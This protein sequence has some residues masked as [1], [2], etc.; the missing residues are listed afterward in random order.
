MLSGLIGEDSIAYSI[1]SCT[2]FLY[3]FSEIQ[4]HENVPEEMNA[5]SK[6]HF[7]KVSISRQQEG[8][9]PQSGGTV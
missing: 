3:S 4:V 2:F 6:V 1:L 7:C 8:K 9:V 5:W